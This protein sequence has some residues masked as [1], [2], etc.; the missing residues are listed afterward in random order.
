MKEKENKKWLLIIEFL[1]FIK[2]SECFSDLIFLLF[3]ILIQ[4]MKESKNKKVFLNSDFFSILEEKHEI[5]VL[6]YK[7][8]DLA[9]MYC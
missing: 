2:F 1:L 6:F 5:I 4:S 9:F 3:F 7:F 8:F